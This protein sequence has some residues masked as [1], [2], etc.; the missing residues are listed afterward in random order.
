MYS[1][2]LDRLVT[3]RG[4]RRTTTAAWSLLSGE[5]RWRARGTALRSR[6]TVTFKGRVSRHRQQREREKT[7]QASAG[8]HN[9]PSR[10]MLDEWHGAGHR[11]LYNS[12]DCGERSH[13]SM[14]AVERRGCCACWLDA[15]TSKSAGRLAWLDASYIRRPATQVPTDR[16]TFT[17]AQSL[18]DGHQSNKEQL[19]CGQNDGH[20]MMMMSATHE[21][22]RQLSIVVH[23]Q[24]DKSPLLM[25][26]C[27]TNIAASRKVYDKVIKKNYDTVNRYTSK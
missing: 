12:R 24:S 22:C 6:L 16:S 23:R 19:L 5:E 17:W 26:Q 21:H 7:K 2:L 27:R 1:R 20:V 15:S 4:W 14:F 18:T 9:Q 8:V 3:R 13:I 11:L 25:I 10:Y